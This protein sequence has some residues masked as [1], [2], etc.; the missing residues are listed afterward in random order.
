MYRKTK[1]Y[2]DRLQQIE[3]MKKLK[4]NPFKEKYNK[5]YNVT[6]C[7]KKK[8]GTSVQTAGRI[9]LLRRMG[10][11]T[12]AH[13]EDFSGTIQL[14]F[15]KNELNETYDILKNFINLGDFIGIQGEMMKTKTGEISILVKNFELLSKCILQLPNKWKGVVDSE[16]C[17]RKRY[18]DLLMNEETVEIFKKRIKMIKFFRKYLDERD[19]YEVETPIL[20]TKASGALAKPFVTHHN[21]L[22]MD[23]YL[24]IAPETYLKRLMVGR[25]ERVYE[26]GRC[27]RNEDYD[28]EHLQDFTMLEFYVAWWNYEDNMDF[29]QEML[30]KLLKEI[31]GS[32]IIT[33]EDKKIDFGKDWPRYTFQQL[34]E[35]DAGIDIS[36]YQTADD[37]LQEIK[38]KGIKIDV[39]KNAGL[40]TIID[41]LYKKVSRP[42]LIQPT[43][44]MAHPID[45]S[46]LA[47]PNDAK[48]QLVDRFQVVTNTWEIVNAYSELI[49]PIK[50]REAF[51][52]QQEAHEAGDEE[53][54]ELDE[55]YLE[56]MSY[57]MPPM[58]GVGIGIDRLATLILNCQS[59]RDVVFFPLMH[60]IS[61]D[62]FYENEK[63]G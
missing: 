19:F 54:L 52:I 6:E 18:L 35:K 24:R 46:P 59:I 44:I 15:S 4:I 55:N 12:F 13:L 31:N 62:K 1:Y 25:F 26:I 61:D 10:K 23:V 40:G 63:N 45:I 22:H 49:D 47:R 33:Y 38:A 48:P 27:F 39:E 57:G 32:L 43:F 11:V 41:K 2:K 29:V 42:N 36:E 16:I 8:L 60:E 34:I 50:Q 14:F 37:L 17:Y 21:S 58:S 20:Q 30:R 28:R 9:K 56:C 3:E 7:L 5:Q 51:E 53:A